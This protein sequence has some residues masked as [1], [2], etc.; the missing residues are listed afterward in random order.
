MII[1]ILLALAVPIIL[2][3][4]AQSM[5]TF[6]GADA[7][8]ANGFLYATWSDPD[9]LARTIIAFVIVFSLVIFVSWL[10]AVVGQYIMRGGNTEKQLKEKGLMRDE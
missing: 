6:T 9:R 1:V 3:S 2:F 5:G 10:M 8:D 4:V 7:L